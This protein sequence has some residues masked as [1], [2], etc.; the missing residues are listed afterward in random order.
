MAVDKPN[1][2]LTLAALEAEVGK[3]EPFVLALRGGKRITFPDIFD[4][5][6]D[7]A[8]T[9]IKDMES[10]GTDLNALERWL[11]ADDFAKYKEAKLTLRTHSALIERVQNYYEQTVGKPGE[12]NASAS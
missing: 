7:E 6:V 3:P 8:E 5:P 12:G 10:A 2:S 9:F 1:I 4:L 11:S